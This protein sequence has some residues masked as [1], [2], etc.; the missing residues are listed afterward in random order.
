MPRSSKHKKVNKVIASELDG[1]F[2]HLI[3]SLSSA[4]LVSSFI[5]SFLTKEE[6]EMLSKRVMLHI[7]L[8]LGFTKSDIAS[9]LGVS[10]ETVRTHNSLWGRAD[11]K[12]R[13][14]IKKL[15][16]KKEVSDRL[17]SFE[18][19]LR[20]VRLLMESKTNMKSRAK[21]IYGDYD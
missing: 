7:L 20:P 12:Y 13:V 21:F 16:R 9:V 5:N 18:K 19:F 10:R 4:E 6:K 3:T 15:A 14:V 1:S 8:E 2:S 11:N 17:K